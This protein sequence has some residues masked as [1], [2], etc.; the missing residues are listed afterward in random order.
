MYELYTQPR[1][2]HPRWALVAS[3]LLLLITVALAQALIQIKT[4]EY[5]VP[6]EPVRVIPRGHL[7][8]ALPAG[9]QERS[10][11][12]PPGVVVS[13]FEASERRPRQLLVRRAPPR[14]YGLPS[15]H[16]ADTAAQA[17]NLLIPSSRPVRDDGP[18]QIGTLPGWTVYA[19]SLSPFDGGRVL[20]C[21]GRSAIGPAG[22]MVTVLLLVPDRIQRADRQLVEQISSH[23]Q[24][25]DAQPVPDPAVAMETAGIHFRPPAGTRFVSHEGPDA[26]VRGQDAVLTGGRG[27]DDA[28]T[29]VLRMIGGHGRSTWFLQ[30][31]RV[32]LIG[33][34]APADLVADHALNALQRADLRQTVDI[35]TVKGREVA[36]L[37]IDAGDGTEPW[38]QI[39]CVRVDDDDALLLVGRHEPD[40]GSALLATCRAVAGGARFD[41]AGEVRFDVAAAEERALNLLDEVRTGAL[42]AWSGPEGR[43]QAYRLA[44][45]ALT[46]GREVRTLEPRTE[47]GPLYW[48][49]DVHVRLDLATPRIDLR[50]SWRIRSDGEEH[51]YT[52]T[53][54][55][56][57]RVEIRYREQRDA[58]LTQVARE[59][60][61]AGT[62]SATSTP[63][64]PLYAPEQVL[65][66]LAGRIAN[67]PEARPAVFEAT[68]PFSSGSHYWLITP[69]GEAPLPGE[70]ADR[71][72]PAAR[73]QRDFA[74]GPI[75]LY[76]DRAGNLLAI[77]MDDGSWR[78]LVASDG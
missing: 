75:L 54:S 41:E 18:G 15:Q 6:L 39:W 16:A 53:R 60:T 52:F 59:L 12:L 72:A 63:I 31:Y 78:E 40:A 35:S 56:S 7:Q 14:P 37:A 19:E 21:L 29:G 61:V 3:A 55:V 71:M 38:I 70:D 28:P 73:L 4:R 1:P 30:V 32:P 8:M 69:I 33:P 51:Q 47:D 57:H 65:L 20:S 58:G 48:G 66:H 42:A 43:S 9:W 22:Q 68:D 76:Y 5:W 23:I 50:E 45:P 13:L 44:S 67:D 49:I 10:E 64:G 26:P 34:R 36:H 2:G 77:A 62:R 24:L 74:P 17:V 11:D 25:L 27:G 46:V